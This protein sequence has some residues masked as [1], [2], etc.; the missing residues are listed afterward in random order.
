MFAQHFKEVKIGQQIWSGVN[1][2]VSTF[3]NG[4]SIPQAKTQAEWL[5]YEEKR[6]PAFA[7]YN[8]EESP[9]PDMGYLY[10]FYAISDPRGI[11][12]KGWHIPNK[13]EAE[14]LLKFY[15]DM[16]ANALKSDGYWENEA[17]R[18]CSLNGENCGVCKED[19]RKVKTKT[20]G[21]GNN[22]SGFN[23]MPAGWI[24]V[25]GF[26][27][28]LDNQTVFWLNEMVPDSKDLAYCLP[29]RFGFNDAYVS[30]QLKGM[31]FSVRLIKK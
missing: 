2:Q 14:E 30:Y 21:S 18:S 7:I 15:G 10:N 5:M 23:A 1:L 26:S 27:D 6:M 31:G 13:K 8:F 24:D 19:R 11:A 9:Q 20:F 22:V 4:D 29:L 16:A 28:K 12:L 25:N 3:Q 17:C